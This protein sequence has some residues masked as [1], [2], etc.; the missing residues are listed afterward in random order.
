MSTASLHSASTLTH[1]PD[2]ENAQ[3]SLPPPKRLRTRALS[4]LLPFT[5]WPPMHNPQSIASTSSPE[6][7]E[8]EKI[9]V[10]TRPALEAA[11]S[12]LNSR[13]RHPRPPSPID[14]VW[15]FLSC[16]RNGVRALRGSTEPANT[17]KDALTRAILDEFMDRLDLVIQRLDERQ[18]IWYNMYNEWVV[19]PCRTSARTNDLV[20]SSILGD[21]RALVPK[22]SHLNYPS[23]RFSELVAKGD[24]IQQEAKDKLTFFSNSQ[25]KQCFKE[26]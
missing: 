22:A 23:W 3:P 4:H 8:I 9:I 24:K 1:R 19:C 11:L 5:S 13:A 2:L 14:E 6:C 15:G 25:E 17:D 12:A 7:C 26:R 21:A 18:D 10:K 20:F 16:V